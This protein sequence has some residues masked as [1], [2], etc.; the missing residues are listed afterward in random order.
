[1]ATDTAS[2]AS[3]HRKRRRA[4]SKRAR[5]VRGLRKSPGRGTT[6]SKTEVVVAVVGIEAEA[7]SGAATPRKEAPGTAT[8]DSSLSITTFYPGTPINR[9]TLVIAM[10]EIRTPFPHI[11]MHVV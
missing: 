2:E 4:E 6:H 5:R 8:S 10:P 3:E 7:G 1:M 9:G 11:P